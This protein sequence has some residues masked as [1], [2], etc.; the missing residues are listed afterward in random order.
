MEDL[1]VGRR[2]HRLVYVSECL[3]GFLDHNL[4]YRKTMTDQFLA[5]HVFN[6]TLILDS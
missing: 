2:I 5:L 6:L 4:V 3:K 1:R